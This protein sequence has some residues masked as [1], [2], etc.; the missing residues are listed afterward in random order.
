M[1]EGINLMDVVSC[2]ID[3]HFEDCSNFI[4]EVLER[5]KG[6]NPIT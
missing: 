1:F 4:T 3:K 6:K 2:K 5:S